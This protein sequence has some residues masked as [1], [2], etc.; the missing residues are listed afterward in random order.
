M[1]ATGVSFATVITLIVV[2][3][4]YMVLAKRTGSPGRVAAELKEFERRFPA[5]HGG[6]DASDHHQPAE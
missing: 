1:I 4:F 2:P 3:T 5:G 6:A